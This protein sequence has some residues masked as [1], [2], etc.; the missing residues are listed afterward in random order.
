MSA[1][2]VSTA[3]ATENK[4]PSSPDKGYFRELS[5]AQDLRPTLRGDADLAYRNAP[6]LPHP[7][8]SLKMALAQDSPNR[9]VSKRVL[10]S[11]AAL[12]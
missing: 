3:T 12:A 6:Q 8:Q 10:A 7:R 1:V 5:V 11:W 4:S 2:P 9:Q